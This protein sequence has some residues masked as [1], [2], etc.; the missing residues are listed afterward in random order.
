MA[1]SVW[2]NMAVLFR[3]FLVISFRQNLVVST[4]R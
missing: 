3:P 2:Q 4:R 1:F